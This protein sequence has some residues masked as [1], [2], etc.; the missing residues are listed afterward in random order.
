ME[1]S[2]N[3]D[4]LHTE[5]DPQAAAEPNAAASESRPLN[6][7]S[8][9][10]A[11]KVLRHSEE[12]YR[13][14]FEAIDDGFC[15]VQ[16]LFEDHT[17]VDYRFL[18]VN[19]AFEQQTGLHNAVGQRMRELEPRH[20][21]HWFET[22]GRVALTG[23]PQRFVSHAAHL[24]DRWYDVFASR[25]GLP[26]ERKVAIVFKDITARKEAQQALVESK[27]LLAQ[28]VAALQ[29]LH[30]MTTRVMAAPDMQHALGEILDASMTLLEA[31]FGNIQLLDSENQT[32]SIVAHSGFQQPFLD[33]FA[34]VDSHDESGCGRALRSGERV[35]IEDVEED[36][37]YAP[38]LA[39]ARQ[40]GYRAVQSTP[41]ISH[42]GEV[43]GVLSNHF[44]RP[45]TL[46]GRARRLL[47]LMARQ[48]ADLIEHLHAEQMLQRRVR[49][50]TAR[51]R[52]L[53][54]RLTLAEQQ[55]RDRIAHILHDDLQQRLYAV[56]LQLTLLRAAFDDGDAEV[57]DAQFE[58]MQDDLEAAID[59]TRRL[60]VDLSP[61]I[62]RDEGL[63]DA[64]GWLA[65]VMKEQYQLEVTIEAAHS[66]PVSD[67]GLRV[68]L[69][70]AVRELLFNVVK[71]AGVRQAHV[72][73][74]AHNGD[75][76]IIVH[77]EGRGF[78]GETALAGAKRSSGLATIS[79]RLNL[80]GGSLQIDSTPGNGA[81]ITLLAP[82][83]R[84]HSY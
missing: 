79:H 33:A 49:Q 11:E 56:Q 6:A 7:G 12:K 10:E 45:T 25:F 81:R 51:L 53:A 3:A 29:R 71:H 82:R 22:Y 13:A 75:V 83:K 43:L 18:E 20:E 44:R 23:E 32:L 1:N 61:A 19:P 24:G 27:T 84:H 59:V 46:S 2:N 63:T 28:E 4:Q 80:V 76:R 70:Q 9:S 55:E 52:H 69:F 30:Q 31:D 8:E 54:S 62:L 68:L 40:A 64:I 42:K 72:R 17:P 34:A 41:L 14:L 65:T 60:N 16:V 50:Q 39:H 78:E 36:A 58:E 15:I 38:Y 48:A 35:M 37:A 21:E 5:S 77:D 73:L 67:E 74:Q 57:F 26:Q 47:D 66:F